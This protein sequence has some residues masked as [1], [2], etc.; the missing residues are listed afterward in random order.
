[1]KGKKEIYE[2]FKI[3]EYNLINQEEPNWR[4]IEDKAHA[5]KDQYQKEIK[6]YEDKLEDER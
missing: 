6:D 1:M 2:Y 5:L 3:D 4:D